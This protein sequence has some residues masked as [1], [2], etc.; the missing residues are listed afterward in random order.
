M[1]ITFD[2]RANAVYFYMAKRVDKPDTRVVNDDVYVDFDVQGRL[3]GV[4]VLDASKRLDLDYLLPV[5][6]ILG[7]EERR[8]HKLRVE[9]LRRKQAD[10][11]VETVV[12]HVKNWIQ[13]VGE[14][15]VVVRSERTGKCR[16]IT[17]QEI[18]DED[19]EK[20]I[21][22][23]KSRIILALRK[24]ARELGCYP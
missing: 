4:E 16:T 17:R 3:V 23:R 8:W 12:Q 10:L 13:E 2:P 7:G 14:N 1:R 11:P 21:I 24:L 6:E 18:E 22:M 20:Y 9:L 15:Y 19:T 5:C